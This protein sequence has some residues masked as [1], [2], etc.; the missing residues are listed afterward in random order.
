M[1]N[2]VISQSLVLTIVVGV[3]WAVVGWI[4]MGGY[5]NA[6]RDREAKLAQEA[7]GGEKPNPRKCL[8]GYSRICKGPDLPPVPDHGYCWECA[9]AQTAKKIRGVFWPS[10]WIGRFASKVRQMGADAAGGDA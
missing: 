8:G 10:F 6:V 3:G 9:D 1:I 5:T 7:A 2:W 4:W